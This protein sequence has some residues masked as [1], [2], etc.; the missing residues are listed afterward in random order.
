[1]GHSICGVLLGVPFDTARAA[2]YDLRSALSNGR[3]TLLPISHYWSAYW[4]AK[5]GGVDGPLDLP[6]GVPAIFPSEGV[7]RTVIAE[8]TARSEP[9][10]AVIMTE[11]FGGNGEQWAVAFQGRRRLSVE[12]WSVNRALELFGIEARA[13]RDAWDVFG[14]ASVRSNPGYLT[15]YVQLCDELGV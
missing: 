9:C 11:Y 2:A 7:V 4:Q 3:C 14:L 8:I 5:R 12:C 1:V 13:G 15:R 6:P 10:F